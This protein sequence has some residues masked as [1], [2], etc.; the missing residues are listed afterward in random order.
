MCKRICVKPPH[1]QHSSSYF[2]VCYLLVS[3][4]QLF[5]GHTV[6]YLQ[7]VE[8]F[9]VEECQE[10]VKTSL[11]YKLNIN[12]VQSAEIYSIL[13]CQMARACVNTTVL[14]PEHG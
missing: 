2:L 1:K 14:A 5:S 7:S 9:V 12:S 11:V 6:V 10:H 4:P 13:R 8:L 3:S